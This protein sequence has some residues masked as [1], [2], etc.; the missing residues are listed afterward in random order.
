VV[1][2]LMAAIPAAI[3]AAVTWRRLVEAPER[4][5]V[6]SPQAAL[7][8]GH[9]MA[10]LTLLLGPAALALAWW[11]GFTP[12]G[13]APWLALLAAPLGVALAVPGRALAVNPAARAAARRLFRGFVE[14][15][16][17]IV[18]ALIVVLRTASAPV[19]DLHTGDPQEYLL[20][21]MGVAM[22]ALLLPLVR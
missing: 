1:Q 4:R 18:D 12:R 7:S 17:R 22:L 16:R 3:A 19:R 11:G 5:A 10:L 13:A 15:E 2:L 20:F 8:L 14:L 9:A 21:I 6:E